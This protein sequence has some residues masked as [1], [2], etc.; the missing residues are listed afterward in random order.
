MPPCSRWFRG[1]TKDG[2]LTISGVKNAIESVEDVRSVMVA[3]YMGSPIYLRDVAT[4][5]G[6]H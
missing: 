4:V 1:R 3:N 2:K 6:W 5:E